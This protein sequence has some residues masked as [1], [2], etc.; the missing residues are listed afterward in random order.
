MDWASSLTYCTCANTK[1]LNETESGEEDLCLSSNDVEM[2]RA[3]DLT[4]KI[5]CDDDDVVQMSVVE[6]SNSGGFVRNSYNITRGSDGTEIVTAANE[7]LFPFE[8]GM[9]I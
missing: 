1:M 7:L 9:P 4:P 8:C 3:M 2:V 5:T 6:F